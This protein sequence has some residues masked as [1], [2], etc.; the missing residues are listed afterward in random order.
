MPHDERCTHVEA[1]PA[2]EELTV[3]TTDSDGPYDW[4]LANAGTWD[5]T[6][7]TATLPAL[8]GRRPARPVALASGPNWHLSQVFH[9]TPRPATAA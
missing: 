4:C 5:M 9:G 6:G 3:D 7:G 8:P 1:K 2:S